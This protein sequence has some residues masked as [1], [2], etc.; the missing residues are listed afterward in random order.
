MSFACGWVRR[1]PAPPASR[2][3]WSARRGALEVGSPAPGLLLAAAGRPGALQGMLARR[4]EAIPAQGARASDP[5]VDPFL[6]G[7]T[8]YARLPAIPGAGP[9]SGPAGQAGG[10]PLRELWLAARREADQYELGAVASLVRTADG[11]LPNPRALAGLVR[12][13]AASL[14]RKA[15]IPEVAARLRALEI[16][17][18]AD[19]LT[20]RGLRLSQAELLALL[21]GALLG[22]DDARSGD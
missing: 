4:L 22:D 5:R 11:A 1:E 2:P 13:A 12:L 8:L 10:L 20:V 19:G 14:L 17:A 16:A 18:D 3:Y 9:G 15:G 7:A 21:Q 6:A